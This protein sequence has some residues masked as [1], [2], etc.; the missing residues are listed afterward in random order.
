[1]ATH[2]YKYQKNLKN[3]INLK[4]AVFYF[5]ND[6]Y[7]YYIIILLITPEHKYFTIISPISIFPLSDAIRGTHKEGEMIE[8]YF[9][10]GIRS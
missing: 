7:I 10:S 8:K 3:K 9:Y 1:M 2:E 5:L 4:L 6:F